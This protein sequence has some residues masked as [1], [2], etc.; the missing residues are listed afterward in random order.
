MGLHDRAAAPRRPRDHFPHN[1]LLTGE[2][3]SL[4]SYTTQAVNAL[5]ML[6]WLIMALS[7]AHASLVRI[8]EVLDETVDITDGPSDAVVEDGSVDFEDVCF[9]YSG[10]PDQACTAPHHRTYQQR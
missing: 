8:N 10:D 5:T 7:R 9:S 1:G 3:V 2:L 4:V 6:T